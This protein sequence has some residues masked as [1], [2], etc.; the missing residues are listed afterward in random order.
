MTG[1]FGKFS[2]AAEPFCCKEFP[3]SG[4]AA[5]TRVWRSVDDTSADKPARNIGLI[6]VDRKPD[7]IYAPH[8]VK[9]LQLAE[10]SQR[11]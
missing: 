9:Q 10:V 5:E 7:L 6:D 2:S 3:L 4:K 1:F 11:T 8:I